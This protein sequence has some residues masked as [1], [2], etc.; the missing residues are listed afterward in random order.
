MQRVLWPVHMRICTL[1]VLLIPQFRVIPLRDLL[2]RRI[3]LSLQKFWFP[4][5]WNEKGIGRKSRTV[6]ATVDRAKDFYD[7]PL[8]KREGVES[9]SQETCQNLIFK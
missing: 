1:I 5:I 6:P 7:K 4:I 3:S 8:C 9:E 2:F